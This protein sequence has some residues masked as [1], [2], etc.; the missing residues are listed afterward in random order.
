MNKF[1]TIFV[2][3]SF[4]SCKKDFA[5]MT[6]HLNGYWE[7]EKAVLEGG[8]EKVF[9][10]NM[11]IDYIEVEN[12]QGFR[13]KVQP[14][15]DGKFTSSQ[16]IERFEVRIENDSLHLYYTTDFDQWKETVLQAENDKLL[17]INTDKKLYYYKRYQPLQLD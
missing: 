7:I 9:D 11:W 15:F 16:V 6:D 1:L 3:L 12:N 5:S 10:I 14:S 4:L 8:E 17:I 2:F 13:S